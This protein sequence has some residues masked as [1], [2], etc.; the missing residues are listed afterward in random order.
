MPWFVEADAGNPGYRIGHD[1]GGTLHRVLAPCPTRG[2]RARA[3]SSGTGARPTSRS[4]ADGAVW[5]TNELKKS[6]GRFVPGGDVTRVHARDMDAAPR[7]RARRARSRTAPDGTLWVAVNGGSFSNTGRQRD[8]P[9]R[10]VATADGDGL[11]ARRG[12][13]AVRGR[14]RTPR[15]TSGSAA[16]P[17]PRRGPIGRL[18]GVVGT[19]RRRRRPDGRRRGTV[20][21]I[22][23]PPAP[24]TDR[25]STPAV[26]V[27]RRRSP[28]RRVKGTSIKAN[29]IC[30]GPPQD[31][32]SLV[33]LIQTHEYVKGFPGAKGSAPSQKLT[34]IGKL[35]VT[36]KGGQKKKVTIKLNAKGKKLL[37]KIKKFKATLTVT[38][39]VKGAKKPKQI[40][41]K[42]VTFK[43][44]SAG[45]AGELDRGGPQVARPVRRLGEGDPRGR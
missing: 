16:S 40:L 4:R 13:G 19:I 21:P 29:Q 30:V 24:T 43:K 35:K 18:A 11:Q 31:K 8:R 27:A 20:T 33:Y 12:A 39:S 36:L 5:Y 10:P 26:T 1:N 14:A 28:T 34:T 2:A 9:D 22:T 7:R 38:Q 42:N 17:G 25:R 15:A 45:A 41:K 37:K 44:S 3:H 6:V 23:P 32:C